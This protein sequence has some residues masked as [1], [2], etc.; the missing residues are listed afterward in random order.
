ML[1]DDAEEKN[2]F[3]CG[4]VTMMMERPARPPDFPPPAGGGEGL[5]N[6][7]LVSLDV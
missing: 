1:E 3:K 2:C 5:L 7:A 4:A 6:G